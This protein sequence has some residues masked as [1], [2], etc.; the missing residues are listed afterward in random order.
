MMNARGQD[1]SRCGSTS[2][3]PPCLWISQSRRH[4]RHA[5]HGMTTG[6]KVIVECP[7]RDETFA[8]HWSTYRRRPSAR[9]KCCVGIRFHRSRARRRRRQSRGPWSAVRPAVRRAASHGATRA[10]SRRRGHAQPDD[11]AA[12]DVPQH[13]ASRVSWHSAIA[14]NSWRTRRAPC[15]GCIVDYLRSRHAQ[16]RGGEFEITSLPTELPHASAASSGADVPDRETQ[17]GA[18]VSWPG[19][20]RGSPSAS[21]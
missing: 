13:L 15:A 12:R 1:A 18:G 7:F 14:A 16:K 20:T 4:L 5:G 17:R 8:A 11:A 19:S 21:T 2:G 10:A 3:T 9:E 6:L